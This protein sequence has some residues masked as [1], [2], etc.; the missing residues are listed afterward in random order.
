MNTIRYLLT[1]VLAGAMLYVPIADAADPPLIRFGRGFAAEEQVWL[2]SARPDLAPNQGKKYQLKQILFRANPQR[3][4]AYL[5]GE[6]DGGTAP[7]LAVIFAR[8]QGVDMKILASICLEAAGSEHFSTTYMAKDGG[9]VKSVKDLKGRTLGVVGIKTA[10]DLWARAGLLN[11]GLTPDVDTKVVPLGFPAMGE[12]VRSGK[13]DAGTFVEPF[14]SAEVA[15]GGLRKLFTAVEA[16]GY[17]HE[18]LDIWFGEKFLKAHPDAVRAFLADYVAVT[19][20]YL[21]NTRQAKTDLHKAGF[22]RTPLAVYLKNSDWKRDPGARV[23]VESLKKL[24]VFMQG[25]LGW[26]EKSV[27]VEDMVDLSYL[28]R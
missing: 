11:A 25:K 20:Y 26:L 13:V 18:L 1:A 8:S 5:A 27:K 19:K 15:K 3:F 22:V 28:P 21:Q 16:V 7:G 12:A 6:L 4:Q 23:D 17:D 24:A 2:M 9:P 10:T 14:Y